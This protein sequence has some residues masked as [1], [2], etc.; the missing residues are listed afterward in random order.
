MYL[1]E[2][3][4]LKFTL[5]TTSYDDMYPGLDHVVF[6]PGTSAFGPDWQ[7]LVAVWAKS[8]EPRRYDVYDRLG[9]RVAQFQQQDMVSM[10][11]V[12][13]FAM[14]G[15]VA[16]ASGS[17]LVVW[18][19][20]SGQ[21]LGT[22]RH[23]APGSDLMDE[24]D[25]H[26]DGK[27]VVAANSMGSKLAFVAALAFH[28]HLYDALTLAKIGCVHAYAGHAPSVFSLA[29]SLEYGVYGWTL[30]HLDPQKDRAHLRVLR[31]GPCGSRCIYWHEG[32]RGQMLRSAPSPD[33]AFLAFLRSED[34]TLC[35]IDCRRGGLVMARQVAHSSGRPIEATQKCLGAAVGPGFWLG[36]S[37]GTLAAVQWMG[38]LW[39]SSIAWWYRSDPGDCRLN[40]QDRQA[41]AAWYARRMCMK[42]QKIQAC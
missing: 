11:S 20:L 33:G 36:W 15:R 22:R 25:G 39:P 5:I 16:V 26:W 7:H 1:L 31:S 6:A 18:D 14:A 38:G 3:G 2:L 35:V 24:S 12:P 28:I 4:S 13:A 29:S 37:H 41:Q 34:T 27:G 23:P 10:G 8:D 9:Q 32:Q 40:C 17:R 42:I 30:L 19:L 21:H